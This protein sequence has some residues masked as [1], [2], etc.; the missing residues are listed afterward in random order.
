MAEPNRYVDVTVVGDEPALASAQEYWRSQGWPLRPGAGRADVTVG[1]YCAARPAAEFAARLASPAF[2]D[3]EPVAASLRT[4]RTRTG[5]WHVRLPRS[6]GWWATLIPRWRQR[7]LVWPPGHCDTHDDMVVARQVMGDRVDDVSS[8][9]LGARERDPRSRSAAERAVILLLVLALAAGVVFGVAS[10]AQW[11][12]GQ[13]LGLGVAIAAAWL[14][15]IVATRRRPLLRTERDWAFGT[16]LLWLVV[17]GIGWLVSPDPAVARDVSPAWSDSAALAFA[18]WMCGGAVALLIVGT[19]VYHLFRSSRTWAVVGALLAFPFAPVFAWLSSI[20]GEIVFT[21][22][23]G[24]PYDVVPVS[25]AAQGIE[26]A[27]DVGVLLA[28]VVVLLALFGWMR[29][30]VPQERLG[31]AV[32]LMCLL[33]LTLYLVIAILGLTT[34]SQNQVRGVVGELRADRSAS[35]MFVPITRVC[36]YTSGGEPVAAHPLATVRTNDSR[37]WLVDLSVDQPR[38]TWTFTPEEVRV[39]RLADGPATCG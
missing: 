37:V 13:F 32:G 16:G 34:F 5:A 12:Q 22:L 38:P 4:A 10:H 1:V 25:L 33:V 20:R 9:T 7:S 8:P 23:L 31:P 24:V 27:R 29:Y 14:A 18:A 3:V 26:T 36:A 2:L 11:P 21:E 19:G 35:L 17:A 6:G 39:E 30:L 15:H 28:V